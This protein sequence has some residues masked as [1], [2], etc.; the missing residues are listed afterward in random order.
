LEG[1]GVG[2][3]ARKKIGL[4]AVIVMLVMVS[5][6]APTLL[7]VTDRAALVVPAATSENVRLLGETETLVPAP[8]KLTVCGLP[9]ALSVMLRVPLTVPAAVGVNVTLI[10]QAV[11]A[12]MPVPQVGDDAEKLLAPAV[13]WMLEKSSVAVPEL[14]TV[15]D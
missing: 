6:V 11:P 9:L 2:R 12:A 10:E 5:A 7:S 4:P 14:V 15:T 3:V 8:L 13:T 1:V